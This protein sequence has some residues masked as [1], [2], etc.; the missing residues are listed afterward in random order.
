M[1]LIMQQ[2]FVQSLH[3]T[4]ITPLYL[5]DLVIIQLNSG[6]P[7]SIIASIPLTPILIRSGVLP[8]IPQAIN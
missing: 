4:V 5:L 2:G 7:G 3:H 1:V 6:I 8:L